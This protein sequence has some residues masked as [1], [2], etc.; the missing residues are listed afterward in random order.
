MPQVIDFETRERIAVIQLAN[1][2]P[3]QY[4][5]NFFNGEDSTLDKPI[6]SSKNLE[7]TLKFEGGV[8]AIQ[9]ADFEHFRYN[10]IGVTRKYMLVN[11]DDCG[12][13]DGD[14]CMISERELKIFKDSL[15]K[16][17]EY[18]LGLHKKER[19]LK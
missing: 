8:C 15:D 3:N 5:I 2:G 6:I 12:D 16:N 11:G 1:I 4:I 9:M 13:D 10:P 7:D 17:L 18:F 19:I 14:N